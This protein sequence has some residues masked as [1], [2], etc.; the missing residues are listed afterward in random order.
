MKH[1][2]LS[3]HLVGTYTSLQLLHSLRVLISNG[4]FGVVACSTTRRL[5]HISIYCAQDRLAHL[6]PRSVIKVGI[7]NIRSYIDS[8]YCS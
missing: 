1:N 7:C 3:L 5:C 4:F 2:G 8:A 6:A